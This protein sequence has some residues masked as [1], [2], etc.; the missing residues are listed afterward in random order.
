MKCTELMKRLE[1]LA[2]TSYAESWDNVGLLAGRKGKEIKKVY[3]AV[4][5]TDEVV[6]DAIEL[7][8]DLLI[9]HH[10]LLFTPVKAITEDDF[11]T[12]RILRMLQADMCYYAMHTNF[13]VMGMADAVADEL[14]LK[15][16]QVLQVTYEDEI[17]KEGIGRYGT[18]SKV[19]TLREC[20]EYVRDTFE[21][22]AVRVYGD[23]DEKVEVI[24][25][26]P[27]SGKG[28][29]KFAIAAG[30]DVLV[31]GDIDH[32]C[33]IDLVSEG[34]SVIDAGHYGLEKTFVPYMQDYFLR[35]IPEIE[36]EVAEDVSP[37]AVI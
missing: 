8:A 22:Q 1:I 2:P 26:Y 19:M 20:A 3:I 10:P 32:H 16:R 28:A 35:N 24:A 12:R 36:V 33:G 31:T 11:V 27:G 34:I 7:G 14:A 17:A 37:Y 21:L 9:T 4:D 6:E 23:L 5:A 15:N 29:G 25:V 13:D 18:F 30:V